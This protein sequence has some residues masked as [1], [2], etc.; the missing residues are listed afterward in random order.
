MLF[1]N[2][3]FVQKSRLDPLLCGMGVWDARGTE[4]TYF[5]YSTAPADLKGD[6]RGMTFEL[7]REG[8]VL[9]GEIPGPYRAGQADTIREPFELIPK[10][11]GAADLRVQGQTNSLKNG[12][13]SDWIKLR[14]TLGTF[15]SRVD[16][17]TRVL[18]RNHADGRTTLYVSPLNFDP[19]SP[20]YAISHPKTYATELAEH[21]GG[22]C[23]H[24]R[25]MPYDTQ[26]LSD[27]VISDEDFRAQWS[28]LMDEDEQMLAHELSRFDAGM[29]F[30]YFEGPDIIQHMFWRGIDAEHPLHKPDDA[31]AQCY[32]RCDAIL[33]RARAAMGTEGTVVVLSDHGFAPFRR[34]VHINAILRD[35]GYLAIK[36]GASQSGELFESVDWGK[37]RAYAVGFNAVYLNR[38][39][40]EAQ[41]VVAASDTA[42]MTSRIAA[43]LEGFVDPDTRERAIKMAYAASASAENASVSPD[44]IVGYARGYRASWETALGAVPSKTVEPNT[45]KWSGDHCIDPDEVPGIFLSSDAKLDAKTLID[46]TGAIGHHMR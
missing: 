27:G 1:Y 45:R 21:V 8:D 40:R 13:W 10:S 42:E 14:F 38:A 23:F 33:G 15:G 37:T 39:G 2:A 3:N 11:D 19:A 24:T 31:I 34:A 35:A 7:R 6:F 17:V 44:L 9:R 30:S 12:R 5:F 20:L 46:V 32:Q 28:T 18:F 4:G 41:G 43:L 36:G 16:V 26:A 22:G 25:G 29:L